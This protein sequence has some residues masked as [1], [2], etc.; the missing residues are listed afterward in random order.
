MNQDKNNTNEGD[1]DTNEGDTNEGDTNEGDTNEG[2]NFETS[3]NAP[4][5]PNE[6]A[7]NRILH[8]VRPGTSS[9]TNDCKE[10]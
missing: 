2:S 7:I 8:S 1:G 3:I 5:N 10:Y 4:I 6:V 9:L